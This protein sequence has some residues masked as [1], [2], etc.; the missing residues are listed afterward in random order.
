MKKVHIDYT[1]LKPVQQENGLYGF[2]TK[3]GEQVFPPQ[4]EDAGNFSEDGFAA[5]KKRGLWGFI[6]VEGRLVLP[7]KWHEF[8]WFIDGYAPVKNENEKWGII[9]N[10]GNTIVPCEWKKAYWPVDEVFIVYDDND[11]ELLIDK[12]GVVTSELSGGS[13]IS[14]SLRD[15]ITFVMCALGLLFFLFSKCKRDDVDGSQRKKTN[16]EIKKNPFISG[17]Y[18]INEGDSSYILYY[19]LMTAFKD[20]PE[21]QEEVSKGLLGVNSKNVEQAV[22]SYVNQFSADSKNDNKKGGARVSYPHMELTLEHKEASYPDLFVVMS[23]Q[24][25][26]RTSFDSRIIKFR[27]DFALDLLNHKLLTIDNVFTPQVADGLKSA[28]D[29]RHVMVIPCFNEMNHQEDVVEIFFEQGRNNFGSQ[30]DSIFSCKSMGAFTTTFASLVDAVR[31]KDKENIIDIPLPFDRLIA[32]DV[33]KDLP[34]TII[35]KLD[36]RNQNIIFRDTA[37]AHPT[38]MIFYYPA[39]GY[40]LFTP[41]AQEY[42]ES[43][44]SNK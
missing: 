7:T 38:N 39:D 3:E 17:E 41:E 1:K 20:I 24:K 26:Y 35:V 44:L 4:W 18:N 12:Y 8:M 34:L 28:A 43:Q 2:Y 30:P 23:A 27:K 25:S 16:T 14:R 36:K 15:I 32:P 19:G 11:K 6:N 29:R 21:Y 13:E 31:K 37:K 42:I 9:D 5:V 40:F 10:K 33:A 22:I